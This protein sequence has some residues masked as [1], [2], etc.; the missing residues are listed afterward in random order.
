MTYSIPVRPTLYDGHL[1][2]SVNEARFAVF[3]NAL[4]VVY[5]YEPRLY[6]FPL[7]ASSPLHPTHPS[8]TLKYIP[9]FVALGMFFELKPKAPTRIEQVKAW[10]LAEQTGQPVYVVWWART[11]RTMLFHAGEVELGW[12]F[13]K[14]TVCGLIG[15]RDN[16]PCGLMTT[17]HPGMVQAR[18]EAKNRVFR[19]KS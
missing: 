16:C 4:G 12:A 17:K 15:L 14:C 1:F 10:L 8:G 3:L 9:D 2:R 11:W 18:L 6:E 19:N 13:R 7:S 5:Q